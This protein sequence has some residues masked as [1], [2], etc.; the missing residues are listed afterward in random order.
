MIDV[1]VSLMHKN[2]IKPISFLA[3]CQY[4]QRELL[5][6]AQ[7]AGNTLSVDRIRR[8]LWGLENRERRLY[9][10]RASLS[11]PWHTTG[12][13][14][15]LHGQAVYSADHRGYGHVKVEHV[16][17]AHHGFAQFSLRES[18]LAQFFQIW[19]LHP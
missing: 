13:R 2:F 15:K 6:C 9:Q 16:P 19:F 7:R 3:F 5:W 17:L 8:S 10:G 18:D 1:V 11:A 4:R 14:E 12:Y